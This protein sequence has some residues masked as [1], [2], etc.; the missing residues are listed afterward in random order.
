MSRIGKKP[1]EI[2][3]DVTVTIEGSVVNVKGPKG[4]L[5]FV[6]RPEIGVTTKEGKIHTDVVI[7]GKKTSALQGMT[8]SI[9]KGM[10]QG[11]SSGYEKKLELVGVGFRAKATGAGVITLTL[12]FSHPIE[13]KAPE[14]ITLEVADNT[15]ISIKGFDKQLVG[16]VAANIRKLR[17]PEPYKGKGI[18]YSDEIVRR[19]QGKS[20]KV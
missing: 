8:N 7:E 16:Q 2:T 18:K 19:K 11:V 10:I 3:K 9:I 13:F 5:S 14:G 1:I 4:A 12:G 6:A 15:S 17:K 20:G